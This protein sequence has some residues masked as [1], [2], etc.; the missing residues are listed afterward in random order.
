MATLRRYPNII[1]RTVITKANILRL[2]AQVCTRS[3]GS[4]LHTA[5]MV[6][7]ADNYNHANVNVVPKLVHRGYH[8]EADPS[9]KYFTAEKFMNDYSTV[10]EEPTET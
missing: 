2:Y 7:M 10:F 3:F 8:R 1:D 6:P 4:S 9:A 5:L